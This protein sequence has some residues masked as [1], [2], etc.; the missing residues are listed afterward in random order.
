MTNIAPPLLHSSDIGAPSVVFALST[1]ERPDDGFH[2]ILAEQVAL[3]GWHLQAIGDDDVHVHEVR[4]AT[5]RMRAVLRMLRDEIGDAAYRR[6][7]V[8]LRDIASDLSEARSSVVQVSVLENLIAEGQVPTASVG[9]L[10]GDLCDR[11]AHASSLVDEELVGDLLRR[12]ETAGASMSR[13]DIA[14]DGSVGS[15]GV[16][17]T[18]RTGRRA[19]AHAYDGGSADEFHLWRKQ[20]KYLR[21]QLEVVRNVGPY[22]D[23][24]MLP[25]LEAI[26]DALGSDNDLVDLARTVESTPPWPGRTA[27]LASIRRQRD[28]LEADIHAVATP[29][30]R[31]TPRSFIDRVL[32]GGVV[33]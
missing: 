29:V 15:G 11:A 24:P 28:S 23:A 9:G 4:K 30:Y 20:V 18:Y 27:I 2:R 17:R 7:N 33:A 1:S 14:K 26:G 22:A 5:K 12:L 10:H 16:R 19:M 31:A 6:A 3:A 32:P 8:S 13:L 25:G 21:H